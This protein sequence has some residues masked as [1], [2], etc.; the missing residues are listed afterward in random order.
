[1]RRRLLTGATVWAG[2]ACFP[3]LA[4]LLIEGEAVAAV[5]EQGHAPPDSQA[6]DLSG[7]HILPGFVD[8]HLH[9]SQAAWFPRG[10]D[11][12]GCAWP[13]RCARS[14]SPPAPNRTRPGCCFGAR[15]GSPGRRASCPPPGSWTRPRRAVVC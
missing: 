6:L 11:A 3:R 2:A 5:G 4:W 7:H 1:M 9:L 12:L 13:T 14:G 10:G 15:R 8:V